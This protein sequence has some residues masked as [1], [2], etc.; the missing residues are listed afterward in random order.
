MSKKLITP[1]VLLALA[2]IST[3]V[4]FYY[5]NEK[6]DELGNAVKNVAKA[7]SEM[8]DNINMPD[9]PDMPDMP[10]LEGLNFPKID[11]AKFDVKKPEGMVMETLNSTYNGSGAK[12]IP[13]V[14]GRVYFLKE[15]LNGC[16]TGYMS[17]MIGRY[18]NS[19][20]IDK[21]VSY[22]TGAEVKIPYKT[23]LAID[24]YHDGK[25][26]ELEKESFLKK[27]SEIVKFNYKILNPI[28][29]LYNAGAS[30]CKLTSKNIYLEFFVK[31]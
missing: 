30:N 12:D 9:V 31:A 19:I 25:M 18:A 17:T 11:F 28:L 16:N 3:G 21:D 26:A 24:K 5:L 1:A 29:N 7:G 4:A 10:K 20:L 15:S 2:A 13:S 8:I 22:Y 14:V 23:S 27:Y 6:P